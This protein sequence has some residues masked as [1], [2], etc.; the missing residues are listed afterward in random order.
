MFVKRVLGEKGQIVV[1]KDMRNYIGIKPGSPIIF[2]ARKSE[3]VI[4]LGEDPRD[5]VEEF[6]SVPKKL[7]K[8]VDI[9]KI[10]ESQ[11]DEEYD[12]H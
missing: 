9:G 12:L 1:P 10:I 5:F 3:I 11:T 7:K 8:E 6:C 4:K 2:E